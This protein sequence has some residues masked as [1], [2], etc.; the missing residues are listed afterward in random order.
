MQVFRP[1]IIED[2]NQI[3]SRD[4]ACVIDDKI[5][6]SNI[7]PDRDQEIQAIQ[8]VLDQIDDSKMLRLPEEAHL[9]ETL[10]PMEIIFLLE[11]IMARIIPII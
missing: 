4:I 2:Y 5:I 7:L 10:C 3:F 8:Y 9:E 1:E 11:P 6:I